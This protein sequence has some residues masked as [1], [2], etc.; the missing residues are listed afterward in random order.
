MS[1]PRAVAPAGAGAA[2]DTVR[3]ALLAAARADA[4]D[5]SRKAESQRDEL[6]DQ[7][8]RT[9]DHLVAEARAAGAADANASLAAR[10]AQTRRE[11]RRSA[12]FAQRELYDELRRRCRTAASALAGTPE[13]AGL[14]QLLIDAARRQL[15]AG[16]A[17]E[18]SPDGGIVA[19]AG[20]ERI[21]LSLPVL[22]DRALARSGSEVAG[23]WTR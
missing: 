8:R 9:A 1:D 14:R 5:M 11:S 3:A 12:L 13:Y 16:A 19:S 20:S 4:A 6:L 15:G 21:D 18:E 2:L 23:L 17:V 22:A 10:M 7:A